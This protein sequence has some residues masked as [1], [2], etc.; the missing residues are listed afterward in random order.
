MHNLVPKDPEPSL[1]LMALA[2]RPGTLV[3]PG[4]AARVEACALGDYDV[5]RLAG[6]LHTGLEHA[7]ALQRAAGEQYEPA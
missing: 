4:R 3:A 5:L 6:G 2:P 1:G 7:E